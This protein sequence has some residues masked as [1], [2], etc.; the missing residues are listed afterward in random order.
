M[1]EA[2]DATET[3]LRGLGFDPTSL[4]GTTGWIRIQALADAVEAVYTSDESKR[5]FEIMARQIFIRFL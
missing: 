3:H 1:S 5:R 4:T 2:L